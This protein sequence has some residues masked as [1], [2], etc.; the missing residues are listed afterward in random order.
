LY[1]LNAMPERPDLLYYRHIAGTAAYP[2]RGKPDIAQVYA[3]VSK[4]WLKPD[5]Q[6]LLYR[7]CRDGEPR[8]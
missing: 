5:M 8:M 3:H 2:V 6:L 1:V 4:V 7:L